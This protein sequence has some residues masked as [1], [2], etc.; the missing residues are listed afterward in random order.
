M[1]LGS[2]TPTLGSRAERVVRVNVSV[3]TWGLGC[4]SSV[5]V[6]GLPRG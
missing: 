3:P 5:G 2:G 1:D 6:E 4:L